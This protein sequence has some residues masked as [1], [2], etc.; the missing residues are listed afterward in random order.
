M[1]DHYKDRYPTSDL[2]G[3][4]IDFPKGWALIRASNTQPVIVA[5]VEADSPAS[6]REIIVD[7]NAEIARFGRENNVQMNMIGEHV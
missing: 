6:V 1:Y 4:R 7:L 2:D 3:A 5:R